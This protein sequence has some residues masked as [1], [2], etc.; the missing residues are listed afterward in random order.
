MSSFNFGNVSIDGRRVGG[1]D[2]KDWPTIQV[3]GKKIRYQPGENLLNRLVII[4][5]AYLTVPGGGRVSM[6]VN[7]VQV[8]AK[9]GQLWVGG[10]KVTFLGGMTVAKTSPVE[11]LKALQ[12]KYPGVGF[13]GDPAMVTIGS[14]VK[15]ADGAHI[16]LTHGLSIEGNSTIGAKAV[17]SGGVI[18]NS[19]IN[20]TVSGGNIAFSTI[21]E[22][23]SVSGG[24]VMHSTLQ[25]G[26]RITRGNVAHCTLKSG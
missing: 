2:H 23:A 8:E 11:R 25:S 1:G 7:G 20:G 15:I 4:D 5:G 21:G 9:D 24:N 19:T 12:E 18:E 10:N 16:E 17:V 14:Q 6:T 22:G 13:S 3:S 26:A